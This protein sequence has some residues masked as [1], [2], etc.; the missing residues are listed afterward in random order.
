MTKKTKPIT[1]MQL[2]KYATRKASNIVQSSLP[3]L[4]DMNSDYGDQL[5]IRS[6]IVLDVSGKT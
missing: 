4:P 2:E 3:A 1:I 5:K 6:R